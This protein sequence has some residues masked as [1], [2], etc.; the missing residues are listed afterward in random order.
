MSEPVFVGIDVASATLEIAWTGCQETWQVAN[1]D[2]GILELGRRM[3]EL[4]PEL[5]V[6]EATGVMSSRPHPHFSFRGWPWQS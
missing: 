2:P 3:A 4:A 5:I 6:L 1:D